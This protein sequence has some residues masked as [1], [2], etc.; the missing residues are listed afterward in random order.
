MTK[1]LKDALLGVGLRSS[2]TA[3]E[4]PSQKG[5]K[6]KQSEKHQRIRTFC[7]VCEFDHGDVERYEHRNPTVNARWICLGCADKLMIDDKFR[8]GQQSEL[9]RRGNFKRFYG[10]T[11]VFPVHSP[12]GTRAKP[13]VNKRP[14]RPKEVER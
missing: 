14:K 8:V 12:E 9:S 10:A 7:E 5:R 1:S 13:T 6:A 2:K 11:K 3:N 4:R